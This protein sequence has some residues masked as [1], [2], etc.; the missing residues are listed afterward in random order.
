[1]SERRHTPECEAVTNKAA[2]DRSAWRLRFS[3]YCPTC[4]AWGGFVEA[5]GGPFEPCA[6][7]LEI[8]ECPRC[9]SSAPHFNALQASCRS[10]GWSVKDSNRGEPAEPRCMCP[11]EVPHV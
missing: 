8:G 10:C 2:L 11:P 6:N 3:Q 7:C 4:M 5:P 9:G 1:M